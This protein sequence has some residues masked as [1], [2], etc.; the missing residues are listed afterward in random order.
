MRNFFLLLPLVTIVALGCG[1]DTP[2]C[3]DV[4]DNDCNG[5]CHCPTGHECV[6]FSSI[7][8]IYG[9]NVCSKSC[10][11]QSDCP[12][13]TYC[14]EATYEITVPPPEVHGECWP[15]CDANRQCRGSTWCHNT[16]LYLGGAPI[17]ACY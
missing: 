14:V 5:S 11:Q 12:A 8:G 1:H 6:E 9:T 10:T 13:D 7:A 16:K 2:V 17:P 15:E 3:E 4:L